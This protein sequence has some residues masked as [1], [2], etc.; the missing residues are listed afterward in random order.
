MKNDSA[1]SAVFCENAFPMTKSRMFSYHLYGPGATMFDVADKRRFAGLTNVLET[2]VEIE[3]HV[4]H[5]FV[6]HQHKHPAYVHV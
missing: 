5:S 3:Q 4:R 1:Q 6:V 2:G